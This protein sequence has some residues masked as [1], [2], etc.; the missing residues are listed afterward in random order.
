MALFLLLIYLRS[1]TGPREE[2][3]VC[4]GER[5]REKHTQLWVLSSAVIKVKLRD[6]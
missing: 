4:E 6:I 5:G 3:C 1:D 2:V